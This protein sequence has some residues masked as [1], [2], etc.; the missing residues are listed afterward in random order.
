M[1]PLERIGGF[2]VLPK[3]QLAWLQTPE[4]RKELLRLQQPWLADSPFHSHRLFERLVITHGS[5]VSG[6]RLEDV[7]LLELIQCKI[8]KR[9]AVLPPRRA[10]LPPRPYRLPR[11]EPDGGDVGEHGS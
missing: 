1:P 11:H 5:A 4:G 8:P 3:S 2:W 6:L 7:G 9:K 10:A